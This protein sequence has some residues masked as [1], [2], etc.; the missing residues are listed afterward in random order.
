MSSGI[1]YIGSRI[2]LISK[3]EIRYEGILYTIDTKES[4]VALQNVR[5]FGTEGRKEGNQIPPSN[6]VYDY[7]IFRG[8]D[9]KDLHVCEAPASQPVAHRPPP[10]DPAIVQP[11]QNQIQ[12]PGVNQIQGPPP[13]N[14][15][16]LYNQFGQYPPHMMPP[17]FPQIPPGYG[18]GYGYFPPTHFQSP[19]NMP[20]GFPPGPAGAQ[21][22]QPVANN[23]PSTASTPSNTGAPA[24]SN[25]T[26][27]PVNLPPVSAPI[28]Q[29]LP[30]I[31]E[32]TTTNA[33][34]SASTSSPAS[35]PAS[36]TAAQTPSTQPPSTNTNANQQK[37]Q[38][39]QP[40]QQ[41]KTAPN[42]APQKY[43][44]PNQPKN[45]PNVNNTNNTANNTTPAPTPSTTT[46]T[47]NTVTPT[48][49]TNNTNAPQKPVQK[50]QKPA[51]KQQIPQTTGA[52]TAASIVA[53][54]N[55]TPNVAPPVAI[56]NTS[57]PSTQPPFKQQPL[58]GNALLPQP[59][60]PPMVR[61]PG[62]RPVHSGRGGMRSNG[63]R[64]NNS[65][66][67]LPPPHHAPYHHPPHFQIQHHSQHHGQHHHQHPHSHHHPHIPSHGLLQHTPNPTPTLS[68]E[69]QEDFDF[70]G[71]NA[72]FS[73]MKVEEV[74]EEQD[75]TS[76][77]DGEDKSEEPSVPLGTPVYNKSKGFFDEL[78]CESLERLEGGSTRPSRQDMMEQRKVDQETFGAVR[79]ASHFNN[80]RR[81]GG[82]GNRRWGNGPQ[83]QGQ[84]NYQ[85]HR[86][87]PRQGPNTSAP[88]QPQV[89][90]Q[91]PKVK[92]EA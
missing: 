15:G 37:Q 2:S 12:G 8:S 67:G 34:G 20:S 55:G 49:N 91:T 54:T 42:Q 66:L 5:S 29:G 16:A 61:G 9:I 39:K 3:S 84:R 23:A 75:K 33:P 7:I 19:P 77:S 59:Q 35:T 92:S 85:G 74:A 38:A 82:P 18:Y 27:A 43:N 78:S 58:P 11:A 73:K 81:G 17:G 76:L 22:P 10:N 40:A 46:N 32:P 45:T 63:N 71:A 88:G 24:T 79:M 50:A 36:N 1:P 30:P 70:E 6:E 64:P 13:P 68:K 52:P 65:V 4:T 87:Y 21:G 62:G 80:M 57:A 90:T 41:Q 69:L 44:K 86:Y 25:A 72:K 14:M 26:P 56:Q 51:P 89:N 47:P 48:A 28:S 60:Q 31:Q 83:H 53:G